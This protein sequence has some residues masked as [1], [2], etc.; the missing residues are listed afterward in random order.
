MAEVFT[1]K[2]IA[3]DDKK[4]RRWFLAYTSKKGAAMNEPI[5]PDKFARSLRDSKESEIEVGFELNDS[6]R[7]FR[8]CPAGEDWQEPAPARNQP[9]NQLGMNN[10]LDQAI[11]REFHNPYNFV[12][13]PER[14]KNTKLIEGELGD[15]E[16][17]GHDRFLA[18]KFGGKLRVRMTVETPLLLPDTARVGVGEVGD[19]AHKSFPVRVKPLLDEQG[20]EVKDATG[21]TIE[22]PDINPTAV[23]G[24]LRS[25]YEAI[26]NSR[27]SVFHK[28]DKK[29]AFRMDA[30][31]GLQ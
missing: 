20:N 21:K 12:P 4:G 16:P 7:P 10:M 13:A 18:D 24:M 26:T 1:G 6:G 2:L 11:K 28:H 15:R 3:K 30:R 14:R 19:D 31:E 27:L 9:D 5:S 29:L 25:A 23:K 17:S 22:V 8:I